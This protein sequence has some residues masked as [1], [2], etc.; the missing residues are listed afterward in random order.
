MKSKKFSKFSRIRRNKRI[1][2]NVLIRGIVKGDPFYSS[3]LTGSTLTG[4]PSPTPT[5]M[6]PTPMPPTPFPVEVEALEVEALEVEA[7]EVEVEASPV[8]I[9]GIVATPP[10]TSGLSS[11]SVKYGDTWRP[12]FVP[13]PGLWPRVSALAHVTWEV[14]I[15]HGGSSAPSLT[16][17]T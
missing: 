7:L 1:R 9:E 4:S 8:T 14:R 11:I 3:T 13:V 12:L 10:P 2:R 5:P 16:K 15:D 6:P 17:P